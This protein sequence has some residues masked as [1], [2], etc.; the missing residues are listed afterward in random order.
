[1]QA[2][3]GQHRQGRGG[4]SSGNL[5][6]ANNTIDAV[7][8]GIFIGCLDAAAAP[9][10]ARGHANITVIGNLFFQTQKLKG[11]ADEDSSM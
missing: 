1:M 10:R 4:A 8:G 9:C 7:F 3:P 6:L 11:R 2:V 5:T